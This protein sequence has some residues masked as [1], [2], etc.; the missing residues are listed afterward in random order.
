M[1]RPHLYVALGG[2]RFTKEAK[3]VRKDFTIT[4]S[5]TATWATTSAT[6]N[7]TTTA[8]TATTIAIISGTFSA[9]HF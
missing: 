7:A 3:L 8:T 2:F 5:S 6:T 4:T 1:P 9:Y